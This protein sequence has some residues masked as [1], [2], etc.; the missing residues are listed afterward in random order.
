MFQTTKDKLDNPESE[1]KT[2]QA[3]REAK[4]VTS[5]AIDTVASVTEG[6]IHHLRDQAREVG[7]KVQHF[8][9]DRGEQ[10]KDARVSAERTIRA[11]P[12]ASAGAAF[13]GGLIIARL[14][15]R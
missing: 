1:F 10:L 4:R 13:L 11:N 7:E 6:S 2:G 14:L 12:L 5:D 15:R 3:K 9:H 8:L